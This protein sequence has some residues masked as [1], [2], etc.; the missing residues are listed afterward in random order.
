MEEWE[1]QQIDEERGMI[2]QTDNDWSPVERRLDTI[3]NNYAMDSAKKELHSQLSQLKTFNRHLKQCK[4]WQPPALRLQHLAAD[5]RFGL[6]LTPQQERQLSEMKV[7]EVMH[8][9][10]QFI[11]RMQEYEYVRDK[12]NTKLLDLSDITERLGKH[13]Q[14]S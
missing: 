10:G 6:H 13:K 7:D 14:K 9:Q 11:S 12:L 8:R 2:F 4:E 1:E 5:D 3:N